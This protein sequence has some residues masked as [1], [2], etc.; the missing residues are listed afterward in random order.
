MKNVAISTSYFGLEG[1]LNFLLVER[2]LLFMLAPQVLVT[3]H[4][5]HRQSPALVPSQHVASQEQFID[6]NTTLPSFCFFSEWEAV[7]GI[8]AGLGP[9]WSRSPAGPPSP[10][11]L[12]SAPADAETLAPPL[13]RKMQQKKKRDFKKIYIF[14][15][16][17]MVSILKVVQWCR[18]HLFK[19][20]LPELQ[21]FTQRLAAVLQVNAG[22][23]LGLQLALCHRV[24]VLGLQDTMLS[25]WAVQF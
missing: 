9:V 18:S 21:L 23:R 20:G 4:T 6:D 25:Y 22:Q 16:P 24:S 17:T 15:V 1:L 13:I 2:D 7:V 19:H 5:K 12:S 11:P 3:H 10:P 8:P 14:S